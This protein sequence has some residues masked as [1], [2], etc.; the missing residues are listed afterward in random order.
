MNKKWI[1]IPIVGIICFVLFT[2]EEKE[3]LN[4]KIKSS[5]KRVINIPQKIILPMDQ[6]ERK[7]FSKEIAQ[8]DLS[9]VIGKS[10]GMIVYNYFHI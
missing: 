1:L 8:E 3:L 2:K 10:K 6:S 9:N 4:K 5:Y 7:S